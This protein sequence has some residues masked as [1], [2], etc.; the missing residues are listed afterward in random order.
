M[1]CSEAQSLLSPHLDRELDLL[2]SMELERHLQTCS[3]CRQ[4]S[5]ATVA[6][7]AAV[8]EKATYFEA[9]P[10]LRAKIVA[11]LP[12]SK[13]T[14]AA[15]SWLNAGLAFALLAIVTWSVYSN[16]PDAHSN[17]HLADEVISGHVR[18]LMANHLTDIASSDRHTVKP[19]FNGRI[20]FSP[21]VIDFAAQG[22]PLIGGRLDYISNR[23]AA[24]LVY[25]HDRHVI[26]LFIWPVKANESSDAKVIERNGYNIVHWVTAG[27]EYW[28]VSDLSSVDLKKFSATVMKSEEAEASSP[29][30]L[31]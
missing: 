20:D 13:R 2:S 29:S 14:I 24:A 25:R 31:R 21:P 23:V 22:F 3:D 8:R 10:A 6:A 18:A 4:R 5:Q 17:A 1:D 9:P 15:P 19:W 7:R 16:L 12:A 26:N 11:S 30:N 27:M 28:A